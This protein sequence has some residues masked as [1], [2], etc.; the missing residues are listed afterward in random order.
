L[1]KKGVKIPL[2]IGPCPN[3][4]LAKYWVLEPPSQG[5]KINGLNK[6]PLLKGW[7]TH[8]SLNTLSG[9]DFFSRNLCKKAIKWEEFGLEEMEGKKFSYFLLTRI[10][11]RTGKEERTKRSLEVIPNKK[12]RAYQE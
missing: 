5:R 1:R 11:F 7:R 10:N 9:L 12:G 4:R 2:K 8:S 6:N 3:K